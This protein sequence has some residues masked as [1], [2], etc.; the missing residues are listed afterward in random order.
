M[1]CEALPGFD[2][3]LSGAK[4]LAQRMFAVMDDKL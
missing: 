4:F 1:K 3:N 2:E